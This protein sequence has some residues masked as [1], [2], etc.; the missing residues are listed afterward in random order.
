M[1]QQGGSLL[2]T[3]I[4][5]LT[6]LIG[7]LLF[8]TI[9]LKADLDLEIYASGER[10]QGPEWQNNSSVKIAS[11]T[12]DFTAPVSDASTNVDSTTQTVKIVDINNPGSAKTISI[13]RPRDCLIGATTVANTFSRLVVDGTEYANT[14]VTFTENVVRTIFVRFRDEGNFGATSGVVSCAR[15]GDLTYTY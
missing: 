5:F 14:T 12:F 6:A 4:S 1:R 10:L 7:V 8:P 2:N 9:V 11:V 3:K 15:P 13:T